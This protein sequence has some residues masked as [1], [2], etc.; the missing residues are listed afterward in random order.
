MRWRVL[1]AGALC[2]LLIIYLASPLIALHSI[3][4]AVQSK[5]TASLT[6]RIDFPALRRSLTKQI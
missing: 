2:I 6:D 5:D 4:S 3:E 1:A